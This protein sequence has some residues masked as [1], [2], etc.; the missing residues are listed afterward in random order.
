MTS[1]LCTA[2]PQGS[3]TVSQVFHK[4]CRDHLSKSFLLHLSNAS[5]PSNE[6]NVT[7]F[8][9]I[10]IQTEFE[11]SRNE[12]FPTTASTIFTYTTSGKLHVPIQNGRYVGGLIQYTH[13]LCI[14]SVNMTDLNTVLYKSKTLF[15]TEVIITPMYPE[16]L[17]RTGML[18]N[19]SYKIC[20]IYWR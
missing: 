7:E 11:L 5:D 12:I 2:K 10:L 9:W 1:I 17:S 15:Y 3:M 19:L 6:N 8:L 14:F 18:K 13:T 20:T 16:R 4:F